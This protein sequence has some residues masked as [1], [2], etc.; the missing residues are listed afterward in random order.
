VGRRQQF[1]ERLA[2][3]ARDLLNEPDAPRT[4]DRVV[5]AAAHTLG[6]EVWASV[7][8]VRARREVD[9]P[10]ASDDRAV[11][12]DQLQYELSEGPCLDAIWEQDTFQIDDMTSTDR[13]PRWSRAVAE[14][15]GIRTSLSL[16]MFTDE[17]QN[18]LGGLNLYSPR[19]GT[20]DARTRG[21]ALAFAAQAAV[22]VTSAQTEDNLRS[23]LVTRTIIGQAQGI[24]MERLKITAPQAF[25]LLSRVPQENNVKLR[26]VA[27]QLAE[28]G[29]VPPRRH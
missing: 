1:D 28:T 17:E 25:D 14:Q 6:P 24:L 21:E 3:I 20:F 9:T 22:A 13:Y 15:T 4:L 19:L 26:D 2:T 11:R 16:Q 5:Q 12:A 23:A 7:S 27:R 10:A 29:E 18:S 8:L